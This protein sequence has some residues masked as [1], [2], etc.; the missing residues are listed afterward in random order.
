MSIV[1][2]Q[3]QDY[4]LRPVRIITDSAPGSAI[5]VILRIVAERLTQIW[6]QQV[7]PVNQPGAGGSIA[8]RPNRRGGA[9]FEFSLPSAWGSATPA[10]G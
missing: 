5:D 10:P 1:S 7:V 6:G 9:T 8:A 4:P 2:A 3:A